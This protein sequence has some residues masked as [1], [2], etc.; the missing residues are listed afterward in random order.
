MLMLPYRNS[1]MVSLLNKKGGKE[2]ILNPKKYNVIHTRIVSSKFS[3]LM[4]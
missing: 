3:V 2:T 1:L 4:G